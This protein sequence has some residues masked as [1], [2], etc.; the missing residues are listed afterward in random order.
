MITTWILNQPVVSGNSVSFSFSPISN[1]QIS[2]VVK[3]TNGGVIVYDSGPIVSGKT[4][5][6]PKVIQQ[7]GIYAAVLVAFGV[8]PVSNTVTFNVS[9]INPTPTPPAITCSQVD[10]DHDGTVTILD[11]SLISSANGTK[12]GDPKF[13][14]AYDLNGD[15][16]ISQADIDIVSGFFL[17]KCGPVAL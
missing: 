8:T 7:S 17:Q 13:N 15:G 9:G 5:V 16:V 1:G 3:N 12:V 14:K 2:L 11:M 6:G 4:T 10:F